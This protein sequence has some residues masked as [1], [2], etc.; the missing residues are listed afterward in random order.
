[1]SDMD[2]VFAVARIRAKEKQLLTDAEFRQM[3]EMKDVDEVMDYLAGR[4][5]GDG[6]SDLTADQMMEQEEE[7][8]RKI[9]QEIKM[10][11]AVD[12][13]LSYPQLYHNLKAGIKEVCTFD[14]HK[15]IFLDIP[16]FGKEK[17]MDILQDRKY[18]ALPE[19]MK[20]TAEKAMDV[21]VK[22]RDGQRCDIWVDKGCLEAIR[23][24]GEKAADEVIRNYARTFVTVSDIKIA[25]RS[26]RTG[27]RM[28]FLQEALAPCDM[29]DIEQL[30]QA[31]VSGRNAFLSFL[32]S[33]G[34][35][36]GADALRSS[37]SAF[38]RWCDAR[39]VKAL[40]MQNGDIES[41]AP[42]VA[43]Y[44][45]RQNEIRKARIILTGKANGFTKE[46]IAERVG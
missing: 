13:V 42:I 2:Y 34:W 11:P 17:V 27:K 44:L 28:K 46:E 19:H 3:T 37:E 16:G 20:V 22:N 26:L 5:W 43:W 40:H 31:V 38:D 1:M 23:A 9:L 8:A 6:S 25:A 41:P 7:K 18:Q 35:Q 12:A 39:V 32:D 29:L 14:E 45:A 15:R 33:H 36:D 21:M 10:E 4:G 30:A 24:A